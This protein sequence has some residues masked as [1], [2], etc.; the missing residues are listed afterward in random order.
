MLCTLIHLPSQLSI[1]FLPIFQ[2][3]HLLFH[4]REVLLM[5]EPLILLRMGLGNI[6]L[7]LMKI[8]MARMIL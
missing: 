8:T 2:V 7:L 4:V 5:E 1:L 6:K 3:L